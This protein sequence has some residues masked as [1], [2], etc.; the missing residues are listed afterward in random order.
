[1]SDFVACLSVLG[2]GA[3]LGLGFC[4]GKW[5]AVELAETFMILRDLL[6]RKK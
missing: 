3:L 5:I 1:M 4:W 6:H 2:I